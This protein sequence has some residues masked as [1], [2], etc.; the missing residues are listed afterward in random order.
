MSNALTIDQAAL[1]AL[2]AEA[3]ALNNPPGQIPPGA[4][5]GERTSKQQGRGLNFDSLRRYQPG[6]DV[7]L[8]DWQATARL[9]S[10]W[11]RMYNEERERPVFM[12]IDQ[13]L[14]MYF[15]TRGHTKSVAAARIAALIAWRC[16]HDGDR[17]GSLIFT[18]DDFTL[19]PCR[20]PKNSLAPLVEQLARFNLDLP[21]RYREDLPGELSLTEMLQR[22]VQRV[23]SGSWLAVISDFHDL[24]K[25]A[26]ALLAD[27]KRRCEI[28]AFVTLDDLHLRLPAH[29]QLSA[30]Y[31]AHQT[32]LNLHAGLRDRI[33][34]SVIA[35]LAD[36]KQRLS[37]IGVRVNQI[38]VSEDLLSQLQRG[39]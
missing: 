4:L 39:M 12:V 16:W 35:R 7:R 26:I 28:S 13:R 10:P 6:D 36:Q 25:R 27:L 19:L 34:Q 20:S 15:A 5:A 18:N 31:Q 3:H 32:T 33:S 17:L 1:M 37:R 30:H 2:A 24:D 23:P 11:I 38:V 29:G 22:M 21:R 8:I 9:R 14:D